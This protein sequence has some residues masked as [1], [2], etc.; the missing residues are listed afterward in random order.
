MEILTGELN[1]QDRKMQ[2]LQMTD[3]VARVEIDGLDNDGLEIDGPENGRRTKNE[4]LTLKDWN[5]QD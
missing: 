4:G 2:D 3:E 5:L 1:L